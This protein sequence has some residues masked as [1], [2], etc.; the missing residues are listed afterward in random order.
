MQPMFASPTAH[1][2]SLMHN[3][4]RGAREKTWSLYL[5]QRAVLPSTQKVRRRVLPRSRGFACHAKRK[6]WLPASFEEHGGHGANAARSYRAQLPAS[7]RPTSRGAVRSGGLF[8]CFARSHVDEHLAMV[9]RRRLRPK[10]TWGSCR[11]PTYSKQVR[12]LLRDKRSFLPARHDRHSLCVTLTQ[13][14]LSDLS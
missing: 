1:R 11:L 3:A 5:L 2:R 4:A 10:R 7:R 13:A 12:R 6:G 14:H 8:G 9:S